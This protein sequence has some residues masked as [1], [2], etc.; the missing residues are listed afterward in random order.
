MIDEQQTQKVLLRTFDLPD[1][2]F[3]SVKGLDSDDH[4]F[5]AERSSGEQSIDS[6][7]L[8]RWYEQSRLAADAQARRDCWLQVD[9][10][11]Y[12]IWGASIRA[13][14]DIDNDGGSRERWEFR[15]DEMRRYRPTPSK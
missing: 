8:D 14:S 15:F 10:R 5:S 11:I 7:A 2:Y 4:S 12:V 6:I 13:R 3:L 1:I 9:G